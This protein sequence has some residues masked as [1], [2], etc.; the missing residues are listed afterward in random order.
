MGGSDG[1]W[2]VPLVVLG[3]IITVALCVVFLSPVILYGLIH[4]IGA[5]L[6]VWYTYWGL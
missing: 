6:H 5:P 3:G 2:W 1:G 4:F